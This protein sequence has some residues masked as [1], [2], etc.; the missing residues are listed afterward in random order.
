MEGSER[1]GHTCQLKN[2]YRNYAAL[3]NRH[4]REQK[5]DENPSKEKIDLFFFA[6]GRCNQC[7]VM[8]LNSRSNF[9]LTRSIASSECLVS[10]WQ[11]VKE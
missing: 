8:L 7:N 1:G 6:S 10:S 4:G 2:F 3:C 11:K 9:L 5:A